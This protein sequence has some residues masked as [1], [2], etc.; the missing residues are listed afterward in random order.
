MRINLLNVVFC[1][2][3]KQAPQLKIKAVESHLNLMQTW[4]EVYKSQLV[5]KVEDKDNQKHFSYFVCRQY[6]GEWE[7]P[8][9]LNFWR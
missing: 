4:K 3:L 9:K 6:E 7:L 8:N 5:S 1:I 2:Q